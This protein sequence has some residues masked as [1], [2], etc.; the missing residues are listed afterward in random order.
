MEQ[1]KKSIFFLFKSPLASGAISEIKTLG[2]R[3][4]GILSFSVCLFGQSCFYH[5]L[6]NDPVT[7]GYTTHKGNSS[8]EITESSVCINLVSLFTESQHRGVN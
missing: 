7:P 5:F 6:Q 2:I 3:V 4:I 8:V 1:N